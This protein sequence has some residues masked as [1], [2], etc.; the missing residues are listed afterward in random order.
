MIS[1]ESSPI[2]AAAWCLIAYLAASAVA[3]GAGL[4]LRGEHPLVVAA[5]ADAAATVCIFCFTLAFDNTSL[6]DPYWS[7]APIPL[8]AYW[9]L[10]PAS[11]GGPPTR[12]LTVLALVSVWGVRLTVNWAR[13]WEG[14]DHEDWRY[15]DVRGWAGRAFWPVS[16]MT[17]Q[18]MPTALVFGGCLPIYVVMT[19]SRP[20]GWLDALAT[21]V[22]I[23]AIWIEA[24]A[25]RQ[26]RRFRRSRDGP[27]R[28][29]DT[30]L[31]AWSRHPNYFG[32]I[33]FWW[34]LFLFALAASPSAWWVGLGPVAI[35]LLFVFVSLPL[36]EKR[37]LARHPEHAERRQRTSAIVPW[38]PRRSD[39]PSRT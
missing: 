14:L 31:W 27:F 26:L 34:G 37:L 2:R 8:A 9:L 6:Y 11:A 5:V 17:L 30:G 24:A 12:Q 28:I 13:H 10:H 33:L 25:D 39:R 20:L 29:L 4:L 19:R 38:P 18:L 3:A 36:M 35:T 16:L 1:T 15:V 7:V 32:E 22:T 21:L 23:A